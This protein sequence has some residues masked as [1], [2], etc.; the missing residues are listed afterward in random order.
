[1]TPTTSSPPVILT[2][3]TVPF[4]I[5]CLRYF[6]SWKVCSGGR[7]DLPDCAVFLFPFNWR[8]NRD[9]GI[10]PGFALRLTII[11]VARGHPQFRTGDTHLQLVKPVF[12]ERHVARIETE[13]V[14]RAQLADDIAESAVEL[15]AER[16]QEGP[17]TRAVCH[18]F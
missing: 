10:G 12:G 14:L 18:E 15:G 3:T 2:R 7:V 1:M 5:N 6:G 16:G 9:A 4:S 11:A 17:A 13:Q 8:R